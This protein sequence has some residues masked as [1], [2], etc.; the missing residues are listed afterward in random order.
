MNTEQT[1]TLSLTDKD[2]QILAA[3]LDEVAFKLAAPLIN[4]INSQLSQK[5]EETVDGT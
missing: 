1:Y 3:A 2:L 4:K 5:R